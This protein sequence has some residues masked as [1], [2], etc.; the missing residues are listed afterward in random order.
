MAM[1]D[2]VFRQINGALRISKGGT[3]TAYAPGSDT[4]ASRGSALSDAFGDMAQH[5]LLLIGPGVFELGATVLTQ[6]PA[7]C[8][9]FGAG[10]MTTRITSTQPGTSGAIL[11][12]G[13][14]CHVADLAVIGLS[15]TNQQTP[16]GINLSSNSYATDVLAERC[17]FQAMDDAVHQ[18]G[19]VTDPGALRWT[20][21]DCKL[22]SKWDCIAIIK[23]LLGS[24][25]DWLFDVIN[26]DIQSIGPR[27]AS[28]TYVRGIY[29]EAGI[30]RVFN[31]P[32]VARNS[33]SNGSEF[34]AAAVTAHYGSVE[35]RNCTIDATNTG[36]AGNYHLYHGS[37]ANGAIRVQGTPYTPSLCSGTITEILGNKNLRAISEDTS[38]ADN[39]EA[40]TDGTGYNVGGATHNSAVAAAVR[41]VSN[42]APASGSM[43]EAI[44]EAGAGLAG[45]GARTVTVTVNDGSTNIQNARVRLTEGANTFTALTNA[46][47]VATFALDDATYTIAITK[48]GYSFTPT[49]Q[50]VDGNESITK[51][52]TA[53]T[54][55]PAADPDQST[56]Y[57]TSRDA[58][59]DAEGAITF[60]FEMQKGPG[61]TGASFDGGTFTADSDVNGLLEVAFVR[62]ATYHGKR[63]DGR[64]FEFVVPDASSFALPEILERA[65]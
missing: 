59:G 48:A 26:C 29:C 14:R 1:T 28:A 50:V 13:H 52:M 25:F 55:T 32:I 58:H 3:E 27:D 23:P 33:G 8:R 63:E 17:W 7:D 47:G 37:G 39:L 16:F 62:G 2:Y 20:I 10:M 51:S 64:W 61:D 31:S 36:S 53:I 4:D 35:L 24:S 15:T 22:R 5:D 40:A 9:V 65:G 44:N 45:S 54:I 42:A 19:G 57:L 60:S 56:G 11:P 49:T 21:K 6:L 12:P 18:T 34:T 46:S 38:A 43:G 41:D 30:V